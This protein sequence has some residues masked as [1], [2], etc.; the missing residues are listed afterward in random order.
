LTCKS[1]ILQHKSETLPNGLL[2]TKTN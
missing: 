2:P 1:L